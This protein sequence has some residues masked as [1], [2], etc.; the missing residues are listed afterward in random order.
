MVGRGIVGHLALEDRAMPFS[1]VYNNHAIHSLLAPQFKASV[2][3]LF[4]GS[5][6]PVCQYL[7]SILSDLSV[8]PSS[9]CQLPLK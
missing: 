9:F 1:E 3:F 7:P 6:M 5:L 2:L 8:K 4:N